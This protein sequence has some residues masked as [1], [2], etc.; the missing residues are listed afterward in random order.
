MPR[1][2]IVAPGYYVY[3][4]TPLY[5]SVIDNNHGQGDITSYGGNGQNAYIIWAGTSA[6]T[7]A[8]AGVAAIAYQAYIAKH[9]GVIVNPNLIKQIIKST[10]SNLE[11]PSNIQGAG[12]VNAS[13]IV[14]YILNPSTSPYFVTG[15]NITYEDQLASSSWLSNIGQFY[16]YYAYSAGDSFADVHDFPVSNDSLLSYSHYDTDLSTSTV[17]QGTTINTQVAIQNSVGNFA[18]SAVHPTLTNTINK[19]YVV[20]NKDNFLGPYNDYLV[21]I[22]LA[23]LPIWSSDYIEITITNIPDFNTVGLYVW[24]DYN[25]DGKIE[26]ANQTNVQTNGAGELGKVQIEGTTN[27]QGYGVLQ[28]GNPG[29]YN[30][31]FFTPILILRGNPQLNDVNKSNWASGDIIGVSIKTYNLYNSWSNAITTS[32]WKTVNGISYWNVSIDTT[33]IPAGY[34]LGFLKF[35][36]TTSGFTEFMPLSVKVGYG[37]IDQTDPSTNPKATPTVIGTYNLEHL[38]STYQVGFQ[39][40]SMIWVPFAVNE[41]KTTTSDVLAIRVTQVSGNNATIGFVLHYDATPNYFDA[42]GFQI[43]DSEYNT[44]TLNGQNVNWQ[45]I[46]W[47]SVGFEQGA[48]V[49][50]FGYLRYQSTTSGGIVNYRIGLFTTNATSP[51]SVKLEMYWHSS[52]PSITSDITTKSALASYCQDSYSTTCLSYTNILFGPNADLELVSKCTQCDPNLPSPSVVFGVQ[53]AVTNLTTGN[54]HYGVDPSYS[55]DYW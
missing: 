39:G 45:Y 35:T 52:M 51:V 4:G 19:T 14:D 1:V 25:G 32:P 44:G 49:S 8:I 50:R 30:N 6:S 7:P 28:I 37:Q 54:F 17:T 23:N 41:S 36:N 15:S 55:V 53:Q 31:S 21:N 11:Y 40:G 42:S 16:W 18:V 33:N 24:H 12:F 48:F 5:H 34:N 47:D 3:S 13:A 20:S 43:F 9:P 26:T 10:A 27:E 46:P 2:D 38:G 29:Q 22:S